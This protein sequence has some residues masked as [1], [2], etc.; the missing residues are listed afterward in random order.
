MNSIIKLFT[1]LLCIGF[2]SICSAQSTDEY[3]YSYHDYFLLKTYLNNRSLNFR[4][5]SR[6]PQ[7][8][9]NETLLY[10]PEVQNTLGFNLHFKHVGVGAR[11]KL[12][13]H[14]NAKPRRDG[15]LPPPKD[16]SEYFDLQVHSFGKKIGFDAYFQKNRGYFITDGDD[17]FN[18]SQN[19]VRLPRRDDLRLQNLSVNVFYN[20]NSDKFSY[21]AAYIHDEKQLKSAGAFILTGSLGYFK[22]KADSSFIPPNSKFGFQPESFYDQTDFYTV[23]I[24][25]GYAHTFVLFKNMYLSG[26]L[27]GLVG[28]QYYEASAKNGYDEG[29]DHYFKGILRA[30]AGYST[31]RWVFGAVFS[32][33][34]QN[35][36]TDFIRYRTINLDTSIFIAY[37]IKT[38]ILKGYH[39]FTDFLRGKKR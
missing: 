38:N 21:R 23:A 3:I 2:N 12:S 30:S 19:G 8:S 36:N 17:I 39:S 32:S 20:F 6:K 7:G 10:K 11:F 18:S 4:L 25:P 14:P 22:A 28:L 34:V 1:I 26:S 37:R 35:L 16:Q 27:S 13:E 24:T 15:S 5:S 33:D 29:F 31:N 9:D